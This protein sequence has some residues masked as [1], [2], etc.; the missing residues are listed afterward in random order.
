GSTARD[1]CA[2][3]DMAISLDQDLQTGVQTSWIR[4]LKEI[5]ADRRSTVLESLAKTWVSLNLT[6]MDDTAFDSISP[7]GAPQV[8]PSADAPPVPYDRALLLRQV[9]E[10]TISGLGIDER[11]QFMRRLDK[12]VNANSAALLQRQ[13]RVEAWQPRLGPL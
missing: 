8:P 13:A 6:P 9:V 12:E 3:A 7:V 2:F 11:R 5:G 10:H 1:R 4:F